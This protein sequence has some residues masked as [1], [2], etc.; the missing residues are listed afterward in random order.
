MHEPTYRGLRVL[1]FGTEQQDLELIEQTLSRADPLSVVRVVGDE[2]SFVHAL[3]EFAPEVVL[4]DYGTTE[5]DVCRAFNV[6]QTRHPE[7]PFLVVSGAFEASATHCL[8][9]GAEDFVAT[10]EITRLPRAIEAALSVRAPFR[11]LS[12][13]QRQVF[14]LLAEGASTRDIAKRLSVSI[15]TVETHRSHVMKRL[16]VRDLASLV[17]YAVRVGLVPAEE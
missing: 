13:R 15:K 9:R 3:D 4:S 17:R 7:S 5:F 12:D 6:V 10:A 16:G 11:R 1:L 14:R 8:K 2:P